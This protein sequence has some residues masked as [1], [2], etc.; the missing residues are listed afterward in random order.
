Q[1]LCRYMV[2]SIRT[3][4]RIDGHIFIGED[5]EP[6]VDG[7]DAPASFIGMHNMAAPQ[8]I[9]EKVVG[10]PSTLGEPLLGT[11]EG[12]WANFEVTVRGQE[13][14]DLAIGNAQTMLEFG[15]H[16]QDNG[17]EGV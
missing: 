9:D 1:L 17:A 7:A 6:S 8:G 14:G 3:A 15:A 12:G 11:D 13:V 4:R 5:P 2:E 10:G 16:G